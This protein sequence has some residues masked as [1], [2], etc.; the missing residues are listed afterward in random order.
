[1]FRRFSPLFSEIHNGIEMAMPRSIPIRW[2]TA[3]KNLWGVET[4]EEVD[5][6]VGFAVC[7]YR[8]DA[9]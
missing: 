3:P 5:D 6:G 4:V 8:G 2:L 7:H 9:F 1:M